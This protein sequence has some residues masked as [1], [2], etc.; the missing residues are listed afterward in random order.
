MIQPAKRLENL[1]PYVFAVAGQHIR[2][3]TAEGIDVIRLDIG[4][5]DKPPPEAVTQ[6]LVQAAQNP[7]NHG[8][9][10][11]QGTPAFRKAVAHYYQQRFGVTVDPEREILPLIGSKEGIINLCLAYLNPGDIVLIPDISYPSYAMGAHL[12]GAEIY[13]M[14]LDRESGFIPDVTQVPDDIAKRAKFLWINYPNNPTGTV[15]SDE[16]YA[17]IT[18]FCIQYD[19]LLVS[20]NPY[21]EITF[22]DYIAGSALQPANALSTTLEF[23]SFSKTYNMAGWRLGAAVGNHEVIRRLLQIKSNMDSGHFLAI[24]EA[25]ITAIEETT[26][27]WEQERNHIYKQ[28]RDRILEALPQIG[29]DAD[30]PKGS[31]YIWAYVENGNGLDYAEAALENAHV[32]LAPGSAY[33]P[34]G[35]RYIRISVSVPDD[36]LEAALNRLK[37]WYP[38]SS[39]A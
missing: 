21:V 16:Q 31:L 10:G 26:E 15:I 5:P 19:I 32:A 9:A 11:Y 28:R 39:F 13:W 30:I 24:Y 3:M 18:D 1:P 35:E 17:A 4:S 25:G 37:D 33:G 12:T 6:R 20:D 8:Y 36:R 27:T 2:K 23:I 29:L 34:G 14:P 7:G 22:D 38:R